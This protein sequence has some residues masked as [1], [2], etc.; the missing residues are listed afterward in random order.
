MWA[1]ALVILAILGVLN[2]LWLQ[3][4]NLFASAMVGAML[5]FF[6]AMAV[7]FR[8]RRPN[9]NQGEPNVQSDG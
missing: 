3:P 4:W 5:P 9:H 8:W 1:V 7:M 6:A 2:V